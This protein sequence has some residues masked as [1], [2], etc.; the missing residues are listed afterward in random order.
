MVSRFGVRRRTVSNH[1]PPG[2]QPPQTIL[3]VLA[4]LV[5][6]VLSLLAPFHPL[7]RY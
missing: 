2:T 1:T 5:L 6:P 7:L 3:R 4:P